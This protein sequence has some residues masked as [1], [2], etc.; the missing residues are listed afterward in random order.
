MN[1]LVVGTNHRYSPIEI[2]EKLLFSKK[3][4][5]EALLSLIKYEGISGAVIISTCNRVELYVTTLDIDIG[6]GS[7]EKFLT[8]YH[9]QELDKI[10]SHL[11]TYIDKEAIEHLFNVSCGLDSQ[12]IGESQIMDQIRFAY[13]EAKRQ[14]ATDELLDKIFDKAIETGIMVRNKTKISEGDIS[15]GSI[16][17]D[18]I[19]KQFGTLKD[20]K[21]MI[22]GVGKISEL[23]IR[24]LRREEAKTVFIANRTYE[25]ALEFAGYIDAEVVK[26]DKL[27]EK[28]KEADIIISATSSPHLIL[29]K[30]D[31][32][33]AV[34]YKLSTINPA[35]PAGRYQ[36]LLI[37][38]L[39][40][41]R[42]VDPEIRYIKDVSLFY[43]DDLTF[44]MEESLNR[45]KQEI[46]NALEIIKE[47]I[48]KLCREESLKLELEPVLLP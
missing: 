39:A 11:Y 2:R 25:K 8:D 10:I 36:P 34:N 13:D 29:K 15:I 35:L 30:E 46:P 5:K 14:G 44:P 7:L 48:E 27:K 47:E 43:L 17:L 28:L 23:V 41:P 18:L 20:R 12:I 31:I 33:E 42:D 19:K 6:V 16:S 22:I 3:R 38:D 40:V 45:R 26:F 21:I 37:I 32:L 24:Y 1:L 4:L 9:Q